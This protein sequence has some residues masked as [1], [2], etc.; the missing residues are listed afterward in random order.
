VKRKIAVVE[1][2]PAIGPMIEGILS[3]EGFDVTVVR[4]GNRALPTLMADRFGAVVLDVML[5]GKDGISILRELRTSPTTENLP[6][7]M[8]TARADDS[9]TWQGWRAGAN[10]YLTKP[11]DPEELV[12]VLR[13]VLA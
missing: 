10:Y 4:D 7:V 12:R 5:P 8:L 13:S 6:V 2:D 1:D 11:F 3:M 9:S